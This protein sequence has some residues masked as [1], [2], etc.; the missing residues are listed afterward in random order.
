MGQ[1]DSKSSEPTTTVLRC[2]LSS[3]KFCSLFMMIDLTLCWVMTFDL[4]ETH[5]WLRLLPL[6]AR[7]GNQRRPFYTT[8]RWSSS[9]V[10]Q[11]MLV[12]FCK[13]ELKFLSSCL[14]NVKNFAYHVRTIEKIQIKLSS[15]LT[16][17]VTTDL[18]LSKFLDGEPFDNGTCVF[19]FRSRRSARRKYVAV[20]WLYA[21]HSKH[22]KYSKKWK[23]FKT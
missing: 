4:I 19:L 2:R 13:T 11:T 1:V 10:L 22:L 21:L 8:S 23:L 5:V 17:L 16:T 20:T 7:T 14:Q 3:L 6:T 9:M 15:W 12:R 18:G